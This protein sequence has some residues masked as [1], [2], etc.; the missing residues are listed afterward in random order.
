MPPDAPTSAILMVF[1][2]ELLYHQT[3]P[4]IRAVPSVPAQSQYAFASS[5]VTLITGRLPRPHP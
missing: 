5:H 1:I 4:G 2:C 3:A